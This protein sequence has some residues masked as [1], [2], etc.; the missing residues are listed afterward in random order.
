MEEKVVPQI[1]LVLALSESLDLISSA[2]V[3]HHEELFF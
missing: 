3:G 2:I 1:D